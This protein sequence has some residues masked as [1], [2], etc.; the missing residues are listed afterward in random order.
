MKQ[1]YSYQE[2]ASQIEQGQTVSF[3]SP[4]TARVRLCQQDEKRVIVTI[5]FFLRDTSIGMIEDEYA[6]IIE[7]LDAFDIDEAAEI[8]E[9]GR[10]L[11]EH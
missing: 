10:L 9:H 8:W 2:L 1:V 3:L 5:T 6:S 7:V 4:L 11:P